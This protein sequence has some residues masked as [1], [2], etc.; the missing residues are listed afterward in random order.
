MVIAAVTS[1]VFNS[2]FFLKAVDL[3]SDLAF[4][5]KVTAVEQD[6]VNALGPIVFVLHAGKIEDAIGRKCWKQEHGQI[7][8]EPTHSSIWRS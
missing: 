7:S 5:T 2:F 1:I 3:S 4:Q 6:T 8:E